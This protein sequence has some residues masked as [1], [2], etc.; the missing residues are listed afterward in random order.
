MAWGRFLAFFFS[1]HFI[2]YYRFDDV[3][4]FTTSTK[5]APGKK[6]ERCAI[7]KLA[8]SELNRCRVY[9]FFCKGGSVV[10]KMI[11]IVRSIG[12]GRHA[13]TTAALKFQ[14]KAIS[15]SIVPLGH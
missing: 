5:C 9:A 13:C 15:K 2:G 12:V 1:L 10:T 11:S 8:A 4:I 6:N 7:S 14:W 3:A